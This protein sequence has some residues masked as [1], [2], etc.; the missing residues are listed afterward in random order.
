MAFHI[1]S[2]WNAISF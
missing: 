1:R 2:L